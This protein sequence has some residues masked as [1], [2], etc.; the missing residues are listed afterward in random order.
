M[1]GNVLGF[2]AGLLYCRKLFCVASADEEIT[3]DTFRFMLI[4]LH[5]M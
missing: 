1:N 2:I 3:A 5:G 4:A